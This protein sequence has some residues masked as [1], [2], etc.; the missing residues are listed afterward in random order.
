MNRP[1]T[2][3]SA[4]LIVTA[5]LCGH[6]AAAAERGFYM[7]V[8]FGQIDKDS[9]T[10]P[11]SDQVLNA[12]FAYRFEPESSEVTF[13]QRDSSYGFFGGWRMSEYFA[14]EG[15]FMDLGEVSYGDVSSGIDH[16]GDRLDEN[17]EINHSADVPGTFNQ[18]LRS[19]TRAINLNAVGVWPVTYRSEVFVKGGVVVSSSQYKG[20]ISD[21]ATSQS[22]SSESKTSLDPTLGVGASYS[23]A[24][25]YALR[26]E[27]QRLFDLG[28]EQI[29]EADAN[30]LSLSVTVTF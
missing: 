22:G 9:A 18:Q 30:L 23:F 17:G 16:I 25:I 12:Y 27:Y 24:D 4:G 26:L 11:F 6:S 5:L 14:L 29:D 28:H 10:A 15:G 21:G 7:G 8:Y 19:V 20:R 1:R 2:A 3:I 13:D